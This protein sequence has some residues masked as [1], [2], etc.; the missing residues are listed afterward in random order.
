[1]FFTLIIIV[2]L[3]IQMTTYKRVLDRPTSFSDKPVER[4]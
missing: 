4:F 1:M 3:D 2:V